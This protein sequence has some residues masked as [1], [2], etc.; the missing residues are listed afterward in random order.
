MEDYCVEYGDKELKFPHRMK[1]F[2]HR[3]LQ[4]ASSM[5]DVAQQK[6]KLLILVGLKCG[7]DVTV[8]VVEY[9]L[10]DERNGKDYPENIL[11]MC[12]LISED[13]KFFAPYFKE[14]ESPMI[15]RAMY[16]YLTE[17]INDYDTIHSMWEK[18]KAHHYMFNACVKYCCEYKEFVGA[19][20]IDHFDPV[21]E[22][23]HWAAR[24]LFLK[25]RLICV[26]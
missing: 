18:E 12:E 17:E 24:T 23:Y 26:K 1:K 9:I 2:L 16:Q 15:L 13:A 8:A 22:F 10:K 11:V 4:I 19:S 5:H 25:Y 7:D 14:V 21:R 6:L 20:S 3:E